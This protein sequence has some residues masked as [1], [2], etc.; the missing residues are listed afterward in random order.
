MAARIPLHSAAGNDEARAVRKIRCPP[1]AGKDRLRLL[2][3]SGE[4]F[5]RLVTRLN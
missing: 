2:A 4:D 3:G 5:P 1:L